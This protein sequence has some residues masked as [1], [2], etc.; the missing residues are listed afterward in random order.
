LSIGQSVDSGFYS[1]FLRLFPE[2]QHVDK[3]ISAFFTAAGHNIL[4]E[5]FFKIFFKNHLI[6]IKVSKVTLSTGPIL[7]PTDILL[8][9]G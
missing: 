6:A 5:I 7:L 1:S 8:T 2:V 9:F 3:T 4:I